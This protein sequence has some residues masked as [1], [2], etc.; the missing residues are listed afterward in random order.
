MRT[1]LTLDDDVA[2]LLRRAVKNGGGSLKDVV[3][4]ALR[5]GLQI[6]KAV[7]ARRYRITPLAI[8]GPLV[9]SLDDVAEVLAVADGDDHA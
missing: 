3:N 2:A 9:S 7:P 6:P 8:G 4:D 5:R 1:T